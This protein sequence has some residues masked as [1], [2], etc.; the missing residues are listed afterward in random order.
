MLLFLKLFVFSVVSSISHNCLSMFN[1]SAMLNVSLSVAVIVFVYVLLIIF[2]FDAS[3]G[4]LLIIF[5]GI[6]SFRNFS[7]SACCPD[8][9]SS[10]SF[11]MFPIIAP[12]MKLFNVLFI[13][14]VV[15]GFML[16]KS[17]YI[18]LYFLYFQF[19][20]FSLLI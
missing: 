10:C 14:S 17:R 2:S 19:L 5:V 12:S 16:F 13:F 1:F 7:F 18:P 20:T 3:V 6:V 8:R 9:S 15:I 11:F 4:F